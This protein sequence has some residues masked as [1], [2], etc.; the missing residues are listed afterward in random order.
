MARSQRGHACEACDLLLLSLYCH[1]P[2]GQGQVRMLQIVQ[3]AGLLESFAK[4]TSK[5]EMLH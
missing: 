1:I 2:P 5:T 3:E 4:Q